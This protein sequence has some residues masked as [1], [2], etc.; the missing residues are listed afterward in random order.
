MKVMSAD[1][2]G[3]VRSVDIDFSATDR[4]AAIYH[5]SLARRLVN[6]TPL[7]QQQA[8]D[9]LVRGIRRLSPAA[10]HAAY[11][12]F[13][14]RSTAAAVAQLGGWEPTTR[15][16]AFDGA[17]DE[18]W[19]R[20][21][22]GEVL[23][24]LGWAEPDAG[25]VVTDLPVVLD[26][27]LGLARQA[28]EV[29][30][31]EAWAEHNRLVQHIVFVA[32]PVRSATLQSTYGA[33]YAEV[34]EASDPLRM[35]ELLLHESGHHSLLLR[36][37]F[38]RFLANPEELGAHALRPDERP[39]R[40]VLHAAFVMCRI[41]DGLRRYERAHPSGG[42]LDGCPVADRIAF[43]E[44][45]LRAALAVL[46]EKARWTPDGQILRASL[47]TYAVQREVTR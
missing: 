13:V 24:S 15:T 5:R 7:A 4:L 32:G 11:R 35:F 20:D 46:D 34:G 31:P 3:Q 39:L 29:A 21:G 14:P 16:T 36:E 25:S 33:V 27:A 9:G 8:L 19:V 43:A 2:T 6:G 23:R 37:Q 22:L 41:A 10:V 40:G 12:G 28:L 26:R 42:P 17:A 18:V 38:T 1:L 44:D 47:G 30:W 45:S